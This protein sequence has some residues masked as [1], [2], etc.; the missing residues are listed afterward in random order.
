MQRACGHEAM[1]LYP[2]R[3]YFRPSVQ[4]SWHFLRRKMILAEDEDVTEFV[5]LWRDSAW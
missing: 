1:V 4:K 2:G 3:P 5:A